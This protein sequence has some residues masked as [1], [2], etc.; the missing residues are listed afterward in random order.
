MEVSSL[1]LIETY[2]ASGFGIGLS[3]QVPKA[4]LSPRVRV[5]PLPDFAPVVLGAL[6]RGKISALLQA[7]LDEFQL[8]AKRFLGS[9]LPAPTNW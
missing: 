9:S 6:W 5:V 2:V 8:R 7:F 1:E 3:V 4:K